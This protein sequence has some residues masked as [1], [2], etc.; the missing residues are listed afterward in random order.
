MK[1]LAIA[2]GVPV[3]AVA[4]KHSMHYVRDETI[5]IANQGGAINRHDDA[6]VDVS[7]VGDKL[8]VTDTGTFKEHNLYPTYSTDDE[9]TWANTWTGKF[10]ISGDSMRAELTLKDRKCSKTKKYSD[11]AGK[12]EPCDPIDKVIKLHCAF[13]EIL[14][15]TPPGKPQDVEMLWSCQADE[16]LGNTPLPWVFG[17]KP[18]CIQ[19]VA[20]RGGTIYKRC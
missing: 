18:A 10:E 11:A 4:A 12:T 8:V 2:I 16:E 19:A 13:H 7:M 5:H 14:L 1:W 3:V 17:G 15:E 9:T 20:D 6:R